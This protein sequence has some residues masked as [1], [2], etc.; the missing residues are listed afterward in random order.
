MLLGELPALQD[1]S[2]W[3]SRFRNIVD[4]LRQLSGEAWDL[5]AQL[6]ERARADN[7]AYVRSQSHSPIN[8]L[9]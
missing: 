6:D 1:G 2:V 9:S 8:A 4:Y 5:D 7:T 3:V